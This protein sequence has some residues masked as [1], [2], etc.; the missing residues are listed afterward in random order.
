MKNKSFLLTLLI[1][2]AFSVLVALGNAPTSHAEEANV[3]DLQSLF[4]SFYNEGVYVKDTVINV[5][6]DVKQEVSYFHAQVSRVKAT[7]YYNKD[8]LWF[9]TGSGYG[10]DGDYL[11]TFRV[12]DGVKGE[13]TTLLDL[14]GMESYYCTLN[15]F[16][17]GVHNSKHSND[18]DL[19][20][21]EGWTVVD[22]VYTSY[23]DGV[24]DGFRLFTAPLWLGKTSENANY[25]NY[26]KATVEV[27]GNSLVMKLWMDA[28]DAEGK[29]VSNAE[30]DGIDSV[31]SQ[32]TIQ[33]L[34]IW[35]GESVSESLEEKDGKLLIQSAADLAYVKASGDTFSGKTLQMI[36]SVYMKESNY[37]IENMAGTFDGNGYSVRG[38]NISNT[39]A[40]TG[41]VR[42]LAAT[43]T[44]EN[45]SVYGKVQGA[46]VASSY[47]AGIVGKSS[48]KVINCHNYA[49]ISAGT[50]TSTLVGGIVGST[51]ADGAN[52]ENCTNN[53]NITAF[54]QVGGIIGTLSYNCNIISCS[55]HGDITSKGSDTAGIVGSI[56]SNGAGIISKCINN[57][58]ILG[59]SV[60]GG[61]IGRSWTKIGTI[62]CSCKNTGSVNTTS[63]TGSKDNII[64]LLA[65]ND[66][67]YE[68]HEWL[69]VET[70]GNTNR[71]ECPCGEEK[72][73]VIDVQI[74]VTS[75]DAIVADECLV[76][77][78]TIAH[79]I[80]VT[81][82]G[83]PSTDG[84][85]YVSS[86]EKVAT[87]DSENVTITGEGTATISVLYN[88]LPVH[89]FDV[90]ATNV[91]HPV[92][93]AEDF[94]KIG[95]SQDT[96]SLKYKLMND[97]DFEGAEVESFSSNATKTTKSF[98]GVFDGQGYTLKNFTLVKSTMASA[99][100]EVSLFG[101]VG[102]DTTK[103]GIVKNLNVTGAKM[104]A[105]GAVIVSW[106]M[107]GS[108][109]ENCSVE[110]TVTDPSGATGGNYCGGIV[111]RAQA[112]SIIKD[113]VAAL[114]ING[115]PNT[116]KLG[117]IVGNNLTTVTNC[118]AIDL[119]EKGLNTIAYANGSGSKVVDSSVYSS[120]SAFYEAVSE[121][122]YPGW[123]FDANKE[124]LPY[125]GVAK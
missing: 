111:M 63:A 119:S 74:D 93:T 89:Q 55:N 46:D 106:L 16:V 31:F 38:L 84:I 23:A 121:S 26:T 88:D 65:A 5:N 113:C 122:S 40:N 124:A 71:Y 81:Q 80:V 51:A 115:T 17:L 58:S 48:G 49:T 114:T 39:V 66:V 3:D 28:T 110:V 118:Q 116:G 83:L 10:T 34:S 54:K 33:P 12:T 112:G 35:D 64:V 60:A 96:M 92:Y 21:E 76:G 36:T 101:N 91:W 102:V 15:D 41:F 14:P 108:T 94:L 19:N 32:A 7:T 24:K 2:A 103:T 100:K 105:P 53:G 98:I 20:L 11:T 69:L 82:N 4:T 56:A 47:T 8:E 27:V 77:E 86:N 45:L 1:I 72:E 95:T 97:I 44:V 57:G 79:E 120:I 117:A 70:N 125:V 67:L 13:E 99:G 37:M 9:S 50:S 30:T 87:V 68:T 62:I 90:T 6:D 123:V 61:V 42:V 78:T 43:G 104:A 73:E 52:I 109:V 25:I 85:T 59:G 22:G 75:V 107:N 29:L 18:A